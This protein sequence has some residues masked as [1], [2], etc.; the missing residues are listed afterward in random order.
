MTTKRFP[1]FDARQSGSMDRITV[2][3]ECFVRIKRD[4]RYWKVLVADDFT[5]MNYIKEFQQFTIDVQR[6]HAHCRMT[7]LFF[8]MPSE[9]MLEQLLRRG[10]FEECHSHLSNKEEDLLRYGKTI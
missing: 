9:N 4:N 1:E 2:H 3:L 10:I 7:E 5:Y 6:F 8:Q